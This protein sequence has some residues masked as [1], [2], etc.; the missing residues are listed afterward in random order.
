MMLM[1][2]LMKRGQRLLPCHPHTTE[3]VTHKGLERTVVY[4][5]RV[6]LV[7]K[8]MHLAGRDFSFSFQ[9]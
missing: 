6:D 7:F 9:S 5:I 1:G 2:L 4:A 8:A 3:Q